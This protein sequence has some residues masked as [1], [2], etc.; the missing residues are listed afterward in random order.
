[1]LFRSGWHCIT[2]FGTAAVALPEG[3]LLV[4]SGELDD[5][6]LPTDTTAWVAVEEP[7]ATS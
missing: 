7:S 6:L 1:M 5:G 4:T 3:T 2:N